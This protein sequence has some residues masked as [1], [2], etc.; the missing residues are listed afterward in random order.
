MKYIHL[1]NE[2]C[3]HQIVFG[4]LNISLPCHHPYKR[5]VCDYPKSDIHSI[6]ASPQ[7]TDWPVKFRG[8]DIDQMVEVFTKKVYGLLKVNVPSCVRKT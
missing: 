7:Q 6:R 2:H 4:E 3:Q 8:L 1:F 5:T